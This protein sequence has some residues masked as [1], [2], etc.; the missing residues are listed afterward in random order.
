MLI[1]TALSISS[2]VLGVNGQLLT[3]AVF[4][5]SSF[6][7]NDGGHVITP[8]FSKFVEGIL[9]ATNIPGLSLAIVRKDGDPEFAAWGRRTEDGAATTSNVRP[10][11]QEY[12]IRCLYGYKTLFH[13]ASCSKAFLASAFGILMDDFASG[14]NTTALPPGLMTFDWNTK[15]KDIMPD[16]SDWSLMDRWAYEKANIRDIL[17]HVSGLPRLVSN[18]HPSID[19]HDATETD[20]T[21]RSDQMVK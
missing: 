2:L 4:D 17:S 12:L 8:E 7:L 5:S 14:K 16:G 15:V 3:Q 6:K 21:F 10:L 19:S 13:L 11:L 1:S 9:N 18:P 20:M